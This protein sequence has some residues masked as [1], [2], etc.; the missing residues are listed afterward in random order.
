[1]PSAPREPR[2]RPS[3]AVYR[4]RRLAVAVLAALVLLLVGWGL[5]ALVNA[6]LPAGG[7]DAEAAPSAAPTP[8]SSPTPAR[9]SASGFTAED[10]MDVAALPACAPTDLRVVA[11][12]DRDEYARGQEA[13]LRLGVTNLS[14]RP[15]RAD[16]GTAAQE[17][18]IEDAQGGQVMSTRVC[19][20]EPAHQEVAL[21]P[22]DQQRAV[23][24]WDGRTSSAD[25][26]RQGGLAEPGRH[27]LTVSLG[28]VRSRPVALVVLEETA[29]PSASPAPSPSASSP[30]SAAP[31]GTATPAPSS[32]A[33][34]PA[35][36][37][38]A[39]TGG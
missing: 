35:L 29:S 5:G 11:S 1:M 25:C 15:C 31:S 3:A 12:S 33:P 7:G 32:A 21:E 9:A 18:R 14:A 22:G 37:A 19:Q 20:A 23:Y 27:A 34:A 36:P 6:L 39:S 16:V 17:F 30:D 8:V 2:P 10:D 28:D 24:R 38:P 4:R 26:T 13:V